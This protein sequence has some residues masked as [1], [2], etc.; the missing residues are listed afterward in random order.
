MIFELISTASGIKP[1]DLL[2]A[3]TFETIQAKVKELVRDKIIV[4]HAVFNDFAV[5]GGFSCLT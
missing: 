1:G 2:G 4:G 5:S 3:P